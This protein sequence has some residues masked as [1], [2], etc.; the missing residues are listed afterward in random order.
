[1]TRVTGSEELQLEMFDRDPCSSFMMESAW[2][3]WG[4]PLLLTYLSV[5]FLSRSIDL[6]SPMVSP[7]GDPVVW[8]FPSLTWEG[9][10]PP[11]R[12]GALFLTPGHAVV[13]GHTQAMSH[14]TRRHSIRQGASHRSRCVPSYPIRI[15]WGKGEGFSPSSFHL[16]PITAPFPTDVPF[17]K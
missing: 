10:E 8:V 3:A 7:S 6:G 5:F 9:G 13:A 4:V 16:S 14:L 2:P 1:M 12:G 17:F 11:T 15:E